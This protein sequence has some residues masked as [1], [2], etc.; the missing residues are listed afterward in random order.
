MVILIHSFCTGLILKIKS[1][2][3]HRFNIDYPLLYQA[4]RVKYYVFI[5]WF[6]NTL[7]YNIKDI[8]RLFTLDC[9]E[10]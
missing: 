9:L 8:E 6:T 7:C 5:G 2:F 3:T 1:H 4:I 10:A